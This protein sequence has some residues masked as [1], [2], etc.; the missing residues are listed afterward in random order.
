MMEVN[1]K[2]I[3]ADVVETSNIV[4]TAGV[5]TDVDV[6]SQMVDTGMTDAAKK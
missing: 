1:A 5:A 2:K 4:D 3:A 6:D